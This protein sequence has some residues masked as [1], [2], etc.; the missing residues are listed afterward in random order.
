MKN[1]FLGAL[2]V[3]NK[4]ESLF[5]PEIIIVSGLPR[6]GTSMLMK[7]LEAGGIPPLTDGIRE[8]DEN[9]PRGY[10]EFERVKALPEGDTAWLSEAEGKAVK[11][12]S[13]LLKYLP[14]YNQYR[15]LYME[16][17]MAEILASQRKMLQD[18]GKDPEK[19][20]DQEMAALFTEHNQGALD[21]LG[22][23]QNI[24]SLILNYNQIIT[25]PEKE[26]QRIADFMEWD[27]NQ[28]AMADVV[29]RR[30]YRQRKP[31]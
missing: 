11:I 19:V 4:Q 16:R 2:L 28:Q 9:N 23:Q 22:Q 3:K 14:D 1:V 21:W 8:A 20:S 15:V 7:I 18:R 24:Q 5:K 31:G 25:E 13:A 26:I 30:L 12:I 17:K 10:Y 29:D 27:L 6:S